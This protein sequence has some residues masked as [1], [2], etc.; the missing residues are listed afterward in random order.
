MRLR[1]C[2][3]CTSLLNRA[4]CQ[5]A[6]VSTIQYRQFPVLRTCIP[7]TR[8]CIPYS[9]RLLLCLHEVRHKKLSLRS[10]CTCLECSPR[11][12]TQRACC[13]PRPVHGDTAGQPHVA[14]WSHLAHTNRWKALEARA[15]DHSTKC[16]HPSFIRVPL[17][18]TTSQPNST[19]VTAS[20]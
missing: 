9:S 5:L 3:M 8:P 4:L 12:C 13:G 14:R 20:Q 10:N 15:C 2:G 6:R 16:V 11:T 17:I 7:A 1:R 19:T 18:A